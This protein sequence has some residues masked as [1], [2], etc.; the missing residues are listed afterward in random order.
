M[1]KLFI[2]LFL[3]V[4][5][6]LQGVNAQQSQDLTSPIPTNPNVKTGTLPNGLKYYI[7]Y[8]KKP[9]NKVELRLAVNAG[10][11]HVKL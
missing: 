8:N 9:E 6:L 7:E 1:K 3:S 5:I 4:F 10:V 11:F 2:A